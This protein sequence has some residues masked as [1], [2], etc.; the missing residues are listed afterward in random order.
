MDLG[1][2]TDKAKDLATEHADQVDDVV[3]KASDMAKDRIE[4]HDDQIDS[5]AA[6]AR[7]LLD[8]GG[9]G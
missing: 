5:A 7:G 3:D 6:K 4:G 1:K 9:A 8:Q 2:L